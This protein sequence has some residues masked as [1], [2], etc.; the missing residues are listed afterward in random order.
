MKLFGNSA[1]G[2]TITNKEGFVNTS[3]ANENDITKKINNPRFKDLEE[4]HKNNYEVTTSYKTI[5]MDLPL[6]IGVAVYHLAKL[7]MLE[8]YYDF[9]DKFIDRSDYEMIEMD[10]DSNYFAFSEDNIEKLIKPELREQ[11]EKEKYNFLPSKSDELHPTFN[12]DGK[13]FT[14]KQYEK[15]T[16]GLFKVET[17][18]DKA[19]A[20]CSKMYCCSDM[21]EKILNLVVKEFKKKEIMLITKKLKMFYLVINKI[22]HIIKV[23]VISLA[24]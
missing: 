12:V 10:T 23:F 9:I 13:R 17:I 20:L 21:D 8:F 3:Y 24:I 6:Q 18:K 16:P 19:I 2:K 11:Y 14:M 5:T 15:R 4:L 7:R 1:Y 22:Q